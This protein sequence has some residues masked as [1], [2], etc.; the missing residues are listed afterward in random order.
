M[1][2][3]VVF[4]SAWGTHTHK[5][6]HMSHQITDLLAYRPPSFINSYVLVLCS[7]ILGLIL[8]LAL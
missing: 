7:Q 6:G 2:V 1:V 3:V 4:L 8:M 5:W